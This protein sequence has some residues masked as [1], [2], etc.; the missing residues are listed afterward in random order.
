MEG[1]VD[2]G[3]SAE[4]PVVEQDALA[5]SSSRSRDLAAP[6]PS[7]ANLARSTMR[8]KPATFELC[9]AE[10]T[11]RPPGSNRRSRRARPRLSP[12]RAVRFGVRTGAPVRAES[13]Q[14]HV[15]QVRPSRTAPGG[16]GPRRWRSRPLEDYSGGERVGGATRS[17]GKT[18]I[19]ARWKT[20][21]GMGWRHH[22]GDLTRNKQRRRR[23][24]DLALR[25][26][27]SRGAQRAAEPQPQ[28]RPAA[29]EPRAVA[30]TQAAAHPKQRLAR[31]RTRAQ[32]AADV[33]RRTTIGPAN[34]HTP[35]AGELNTNAAW[36]WSGTGR[37]SDDDRAAGQARI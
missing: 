20:P 10:A 33:A 27:A 30:E 19:T 22:G 26:S 4:A 11:Q 18:L 34:R 24:S 23:R 9:I 28:L 7:V 8:G 29:T 14:A 2:P 32:P 15:G 35:P 17:R 25:P 12:G 1:S 21:S 37:W 13:A 36:S 5:D 3:P 16:R 6:E 31:S